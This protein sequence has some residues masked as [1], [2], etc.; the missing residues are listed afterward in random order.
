MCPV[1]T[2]V[3]GRYPLFR[4]RCRHEAVKYQLDDQLRARRSARY[5]W[6]HPIVVA[7]FG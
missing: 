6:D 5:G 4:A 3:S 7:D 1:V 2:A